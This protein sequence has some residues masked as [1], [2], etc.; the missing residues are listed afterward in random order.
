MSEI[1]H[2]EKVY[3]F[4]LTRPVMPGSRAVCRVCCAARTHR[5]AERIANTVPG[6]KSGPGQV[7]KR[8]APCA[9]GTAE[10]LI[11]TTR[12]GE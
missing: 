10:G 6:W 12:E 1:V 9:S 11:S 2:A 3:T 4:I 7:C 8:I 5:R